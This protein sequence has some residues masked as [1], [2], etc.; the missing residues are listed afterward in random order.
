MFS[1][2]KQNIYSTLGVNAYK[3]TACKTKGED[4]SPHF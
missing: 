1:Y 3:S 4:I 2:K